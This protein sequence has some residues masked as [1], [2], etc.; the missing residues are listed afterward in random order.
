MTSL[1]FPLLDSLLACFVALAGFSTYILWAPT[2][3]LQLILDLM[4]IDSSFKLQLTAIVILNIVL[5]FASE[6]WAEGAIV[7]AYSKARSW[8]RRRSRGARHVKGPAYK[9]IT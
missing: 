6:R 2:V 9:R 7:N 5:C 1:S 8:L 4:S 3:A